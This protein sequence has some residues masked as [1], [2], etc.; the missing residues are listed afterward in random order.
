MQPDDGGV[1]GDKRKEARQCP[2]IVAA[3]KFKRRLTEDWEGSWREERRLSWAAMGRVEFVIVDSKYNEN[4]WLRLCLAYISITFCPR[5]ESSD[6]DYTT[7][8]R[9]CPGKCYKWRATTLHDNCFFDPIY[10][11]IISS[12]A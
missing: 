10:E 7:A 1:K 9:S 8:T 4:R 3:A 5:G 11:V 2:D 12:L 6:C